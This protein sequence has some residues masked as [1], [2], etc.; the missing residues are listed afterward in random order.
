LKIRVEGLFLTL[1]FNEEYF[2]DLCQIS[3]KNQSVA[4]AEDALE[5]FRK[6]RGQALFRQPGYPL[7]FNRPPAFFP[8]SLALRLI[9]GFAAIRS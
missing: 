8:V 7:W 9:G 1:F 5:G 6:G 4:K 3:L 2:P